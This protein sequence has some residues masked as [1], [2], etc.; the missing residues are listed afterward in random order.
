MKS[1]KYFALIFFAIAGEINAQDIL[2]YKYKAL[3]LPTD[4]TQMELLLNDKSVKRRKKIN[5]ENI[6]GNQDKVTRSLVTSEFYKFAIPPV[7]NGSNISPNPIS[8]INSNFSESKLTAKVGFPFHQ[9]LEPKDF[10]KSGFIEVGVRAANGIATLYKSKNPPLEFSFSGGFSFITNHAVFVSTLDHTLKTTEQIN[11]INILGSYEV[12]NYNLFDISSSYD[13]VK[14]T[15]ST[16]NHSAM[17]SFNR[18]FYSNQPRLRLMNFIFSAG[19]GIAKTNNYSSLKKRDFEEGTIINSPNGS[20][21]RSVAETVSGAIG[22]FKQFE[23]M[24]YYLEIFKAIIQ[25]NNWGSIYYGNRLTHYAVGR[26]QTIINGTTG[27]YFHLKNGAKDM[28]DVKD[29]L[30]FSI[31]GRFNQ[32]NKRDE[33]DYLDNNFSI[34]AQIGV[35]IRF[36]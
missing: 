16:N 25:S 30:S 26:D 31:T 24:A 4:N 5:V 17:I 33:T 2:Q 19:I 7:I 11:W 35:P 12:N 21:Y 36:N 29:V 1:I 18:Y 22:E 27:F 23:G 10:S 3:R 32:I 9:K 14:R 28:K 6:N 20:T 8:N 13:N 34:I 15:I